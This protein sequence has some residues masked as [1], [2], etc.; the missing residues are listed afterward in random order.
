MFVDLLRQLKPA[1]RRLQELALIPAL[2]RKLQRNS[3]RRT[4]QADSLP[5]PA[6]AGGSLPNR[7]LTVRGS[8][9]SAG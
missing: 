4:P 6:D 1:A 5:P 9:F 3:A 8:L 7:R 2:E